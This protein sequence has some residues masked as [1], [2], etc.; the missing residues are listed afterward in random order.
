MP[1]YNTLIQQCSTKFFSNT[2]LQHS[3]TTHLS[4]T[5]PILFSK[6]VLQ[7]FS[8]TTF[9]STSLQFSST[10]LYNTSLQHFSTTL[11]YHT[12]L[13][14]PSPTL[15]SISLPQHFSTTVLYIPHFSAT[16]FSSSFLQL[17][18][19]RRQTESQYIYLILEKVK[20]CKCI[21]ALIYSIYVYIG[22]ILFPPSASLRSGREVGTPEG[23]PWNGT[24]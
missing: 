4:H 17:C 23:T 8:T 15:L 1:L 10:L 21:F 5:S 7:H 19:F 2:S 16:L 3:S 9:S 20:Q 13:Q 12:S 14:H 11:L 18:D 22:C 24:A 6:S